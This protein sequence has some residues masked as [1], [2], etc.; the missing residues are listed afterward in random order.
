MLLNALII[1]S[2]PSSVN[3]IGFSTTGK[4]Q[5]AKGVAELLGWPRH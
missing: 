1:E 4:S 5:I 2:A 3:A